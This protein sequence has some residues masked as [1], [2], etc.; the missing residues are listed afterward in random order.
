ELPGLPAELQPP[1]RAGF[2]ATH[3]LLEGAWR[4]YVDAVDAILVEQPFFF[5]ERF[6]VADA[7]V[8]GCLGMNL[9]D[10]E[11]CDVLRS[12]SLRTYS[13]LCDIRDRR[14]VLTRGALALHPRL[15]PLLMLIGRTFGPLMQQNEAAYEHARARRETCFAERAF[16]RGLAL[17]DGELLG[18]AFRAVAKPF[19][20][21]V[22]RELRAAWHAL[23]PDARRG[24]DLLT[25]GAADTWLAP[26]ASPRAEAERAGA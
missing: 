23:P 18:H 15:A 24:V 17:Y 20:V 10:P 16:N 14:H 8:Y 12:R 13:W 11:A 1:S 7:S 26:L 6:T 3:T 9:R 22:W 21:R 19:Q 25:E 4:A 5:G 2:P